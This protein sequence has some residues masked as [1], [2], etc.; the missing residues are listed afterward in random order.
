MPPP[1]PSVHS[2]NE[3]DCNSV[4]T[5][6]Q[7]VEL[8]GLRTFDERLELTGREVEDGTVWILGVTDP[9]ATVSEWSNLNTVARPVAACALAPDPAGLDALHCIGPSYVLAAAAMRAADVR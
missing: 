9:Y 8:A 5:L 2:A 6:N 1:V 3:K 7:L 4:D